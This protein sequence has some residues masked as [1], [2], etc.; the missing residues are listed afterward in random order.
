MEDCKLN[1]KILLGDVMEK[2]K[3]IPDESIDCVI[4]S[5]PY[6]L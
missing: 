6:L 3:E 1:R 5:P 2:M 4:T